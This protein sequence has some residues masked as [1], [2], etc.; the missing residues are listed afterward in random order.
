[1]TQ[2]RKL[3]AVRAIVRPDQRPLYL[4]RW[5]RYARAAEEAGAQVRLLED[6][7]LPGRFLELIEHDAAVG[8]EGELRRAGREAELRRYCVRREGEDV[9]YRE[10]ELGVRG[11]RP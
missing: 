7:A 10:A 8:M 2:I 3:R 4:E 1:M 6:Q 9:L 11:E 5:K